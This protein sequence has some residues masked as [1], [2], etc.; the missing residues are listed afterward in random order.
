MNLAL[1]E[2]CACARIWGILPCAADGRDLKYT[3]FVEQGETDITLALQR[4]EV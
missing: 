1:K 2:E 3:K 4:E